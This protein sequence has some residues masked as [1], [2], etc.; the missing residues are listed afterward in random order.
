MKKRG[1][2]YTLRGNGGDGSLSEGRGA[3]SKGGKKRKAVRLGEKS[4][5]S[6]WQKEDNSVERQKT[7]RPAEGS[8]YFKGGRIINSP[9][10]FLFGTA[11]GTQ[12]KKGNEVRSEEGE[13]GGLSID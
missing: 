8:F 12:R 10:E 5:Q 6:N 7:S 11:K 13:G 1:D 9:E 2:F 3:C 4:N